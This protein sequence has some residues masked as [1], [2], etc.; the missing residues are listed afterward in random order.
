MTAA[1]MAATILV[2]VVIALALFGMW[3]LVKLP[4]AINALRADHARQEHD[5]AEASGDLDTLRELLRPVVEDEVNSHLTLIYAPIYLDA[6]AWSEA[7]RAD[8]DE[9]TRWGR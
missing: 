3:A 8:W 1:N 6:L 7:A 5:A 9:P 4:A 2:A